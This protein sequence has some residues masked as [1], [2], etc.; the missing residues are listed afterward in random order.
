MET[1]VHAPRVDEEQNIVLQVDIIY[2]TEEFLRMNSSVFNFA[3]SMQPGR[4][5]AKNLL[6]NKPTQPE[7]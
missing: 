1:K 4:F 2:T 5:D 7:G 6:E 3:E